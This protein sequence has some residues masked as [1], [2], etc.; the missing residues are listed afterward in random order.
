MEITRTRLNIIH[1]AINVM[2][3]YTSDPEADEYIECVLDVF[4]IDYFIDEYHR[5]RY[6]RFP[7][8]NHITEEY[9]KDNFD[10]I[11]Y[12]QIPNISNLTIAEFSTCM[13]NILESMMSLLSDERSNSMVQ[14]LIIRKIY[15]P[16][17]R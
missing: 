7:S 13:D 2:Y 1:D 5:E 10:K 8:N 17:N 14:D 9:M 16:E 6:L 4:F 11:H 15:R 12:I 3:D